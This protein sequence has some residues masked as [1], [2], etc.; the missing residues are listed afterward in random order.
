MIYMCITQRPLEVDNDNDSD[1]D[2][3]SVVVEVGGMKV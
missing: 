2:T 3:R 1:S